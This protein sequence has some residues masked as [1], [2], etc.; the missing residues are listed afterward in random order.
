MTHP[1]MVMP[2]TSPMAAVRS[3]RGDGRRENGEA[4][5][6]DKTGENEFLDLH[7]IPLR[8]LQMGRL[9]QRLPVNGTYAQAD[10][11]GV[12]KTWCRFQ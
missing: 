3:R 9:E 4:G 10:D 1:M 12:E 2:V 6:S 11:R 5:K 8:R 7:E